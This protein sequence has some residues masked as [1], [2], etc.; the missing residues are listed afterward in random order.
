MEL[1]INSLLI[2]IPVYVP[3]S[4]E[5]SAEFFDNVVSGFFIASAAWDVNPGGFFSR[6]VRI[7]LSPGDAVPQHPVRRDIHRQMKLA[8][9]MASPKFL[10]SGPSPTHAEHPIQSCRV[11]AKASEGEIQLLRTVLVAQISLHCRTSYRG[12]ER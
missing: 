9:P 8:G 6:R 12:H 7:P 10:A 4:S 5:M 3:A 11:L 1:I 2:C